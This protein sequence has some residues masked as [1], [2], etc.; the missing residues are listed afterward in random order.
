MVLDPDEERLGPSR[1]GRLSEQRR[2]LSSTTTIRSTPRLSSMTLVSLL[3]SPST[4]YFALKDCA[5]LLN[6][7]LAL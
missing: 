3:C 6:R 4:V 1:T 5:S 7:S 2:G